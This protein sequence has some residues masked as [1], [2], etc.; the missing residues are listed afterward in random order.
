MFVAFD[1]VAH[2]QWHILTCLRIKKAQTYWGMLIII[3][4]TPILEWLDV[5]RLFLS[6]RPLTLFTHSRL[7]RAN[8]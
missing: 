5:T 6:M 7:L 2:L 1:V 4:F 8:N 3:I